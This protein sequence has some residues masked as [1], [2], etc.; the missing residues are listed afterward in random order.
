MSEENKTENDVVKAE[1]YNK[2]V[3]AHNA[4]KLEKENLEKEIKTMKEKE[5][6]SKNESEKMSWEKE[7][8]EK[9]A[10]IAELN[11]KVEDNTKNPKGIVNDQRQQEPANAG[12]EQVKKMLDEVIP[13]DDFKPDK[14]GSRI[15]R[16]GHY[17]NPATKRFNNTQMGMGLS[18]HKGAMAV[19][20]ELIPDAARA[21]RDDIIVKN[22]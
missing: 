22:K 3:S 14:C 13:D 19:N 4:V 6:S 16:Y 10:K 15:A 12:K 18:L 21:S 17:K 5:I 9:D 20:P 11:K 7:R 2:V 1:E 8:L